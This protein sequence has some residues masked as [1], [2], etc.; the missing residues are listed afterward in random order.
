MAL[1][2]I[3]A[4]GFPVSAQ[5]Q[6]LNQP[7][8]SIEIEPD[9]HLW[10]EGSASIVKY[11]CRA[12]ALSGLG[13]IENVKYP[14]ENIQGH[15]HVSI[16]VQIPVHSL[17]CGKRAMNKDMYEALKAERHPKIGYQLLEASLLGQEDSGWMM[18]RT[19]G[20]LEIAGVNDTTEVMVHGK[21]LNEEQFRVRGNKELEM[22][23]FNVTPPTALLGLI[24]ADKEL[25]VHFDVTVRLQDSLVSSSAPSLTY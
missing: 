5:D 4:G 3:T 15:G 22:T 8:G 19:R 20:I 16:V 18:I 21:M 7:S 17:D 25:T 6:S 10:I 14:Q 11:K 9:G 1:L 13:A 23:D 24:K 2:I 12:E